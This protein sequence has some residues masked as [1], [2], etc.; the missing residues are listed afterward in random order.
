VIVAVDHVVSAKS[1][2]AVVPDV[3]GATTVNVLP[4]AVYPV[5][6]TSFVVAYAVVD[7]PR[8]ADEVNNAILNV[9]D[10]SELKSISPS[11]SAFLNDV[12]IA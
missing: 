6:D 7:A 2:N 8:V 9:A 12:H 5:P 11:R 4:P 1:R 10:V 3:V